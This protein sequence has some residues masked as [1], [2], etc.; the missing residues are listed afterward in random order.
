MFQLDR[1]RAGLVRLGSGRKNNRRI[2]F[3]PLLI[4][5]EADI[6]ARLSIAA[7]AGILVSFWLVMVCFPTVPESLADLSSR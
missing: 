5:A 2:S 4:F 1:V 3:S 6:E 7:K